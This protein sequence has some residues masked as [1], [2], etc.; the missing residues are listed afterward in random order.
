MD[1]NARELTLAIDGNEAYIFCS[2]VLQHRL[3][4]LLFPLLLVSPEKKYLRN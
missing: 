4:E 3:Q 1:K 2:P